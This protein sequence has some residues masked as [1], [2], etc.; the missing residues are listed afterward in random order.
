MVTARRQDGNLREDT[1]VDFCSTKGVR[2]RPSFTWSRLL[3]VSSLQISKISQ[4]FAGTFLPTSIMALDR[5]GN[6]KREEFAYLFCGKLR[7]LSHQEADALLG[8]L[9]RYVYVLLSCHRR[10]WRTVL[11]V[12]I[13]L[14]LA[15][16]FMSPLGTYP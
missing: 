12:Y 5:S 6:I 2:A 14:A 7:L 10:I 9:D 13:P 3:V 8:V 15:F 4:G 11:D 16:G 1:R